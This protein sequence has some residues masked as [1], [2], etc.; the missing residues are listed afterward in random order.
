[1][2]LF[3][4]TDYLRCKKLLK[5]NSIALHEDS[6]LY[7]PIGKEANISHPHDKLYRDLL[8]NKKEFSL[9]LQDFFCYL[10]QSNFVKYNRSFITK[11]YSSKYSDVIFRL[12]SKP[13]YLLVEHQS[14]V[15][16]SIPYRIYKYYNC[17]LD[18][19]VDSTKVKNKNYNI[20]LITPIILYTGN[21]SWNFLPNFQEHQFDYTYNN[22]LN[23]GRLSL[24]YNFINIHDFSKEE[25]LKK[26]SMIAYAMAIDKCSNVTELIDTINSVYD[27]CSDEQREYLY[28]MIKY[29]LKPLL[30]KE[31]YEALLRK[32]DKEEET[33][34]E[35]LIERMKKDLE[36]RRKKA[37]SEGMARGIAKGK[38][39]ANIEAAKKMLE[40]NM[41]V[42]DI[43]EIT[44]LSIKE[45]NKL[46]IA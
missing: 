6:S 34:M 31:T 12:K 42:E 22:K 21:Q 23:S 10:L 30:P 33:Y 16:Y 3:T 14:Y 9:F 29:I 19:T 18:D 38:L 7:L 39:E 28:R 8:N 25:L 11:D 20:P 17:I 36:Y 26:H 15:D 35:E 40:H 27:L 1:M 43:S 45:I 46:K 5:G 44:G 24:A 41:L 32:F 4:Y 2:V 13:V 37:E